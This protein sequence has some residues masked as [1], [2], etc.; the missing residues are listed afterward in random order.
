MIKIIKAT[1]L[2][3]VFMSCQKNKKKVLTDAELMAVF[4]LFSRIKKRKMFLSLENSCDN[5]QNANTLQM[6]SV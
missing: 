5:L 6:L 4:H 2:T 3:N 1:L